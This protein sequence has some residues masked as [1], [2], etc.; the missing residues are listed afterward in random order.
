MQFARLQHRKERTGKR[1]QSRRKNGNAEYSPCR[2]E[3]GKVGHGRIRGAPSRMRDLPEDERAAYE[4]GTARERRGA[5]GRARLRARL[6]DRRQRKSEVRHG[7]QDALPRLGGTGQFRRAASARHNHKEDEQR[8]KE[9]V[10][11]ARAADP[12]FQQKRKHAERTKC[13]PGS[14]LR[15]E[16]VHA[17]EH[18]R[19]RDKGERKHQTPCRA[20]LPARKA[21]QRL[22]K[23]P[24]PFPETKEK[25][26]CRG[27]H[28]AGERKRKKIPFS[29]KEADKFRP[30][31]KSRARH[32]PHEKE[33][34][35]YYPHSFMDI[36][37]KIKKFLK[38]FRNYV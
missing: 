5:H 37:A 3:R 33:R 1:R 12:L 22:R 11:Q 25:G 31:Q 34:S 35:P 24:V 15:K 26:A 32:R 8:H 18:P 16:R 28:K 13:D 10:E 19:A 14:R 27:I 7:I 20:R 6:Q 38:K 2:P 21:L 23:A 9:R 36:P 4:H 30:C 17:R 29:A